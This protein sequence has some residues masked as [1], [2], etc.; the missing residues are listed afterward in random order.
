MNPRAHAEQVT[1]Q[2][3][4]SI[5]DLWSSLGFAAALSDVTGPRVYEY[6]VLPVS[7]VAITLYDVRRHVLIEDGRV[8]RDAAVRAG[9]FRIGI[10]GREVVV[11]AV[12]NVTSGKLVLLYLGEPLLA[13]AGIAFGRDIP[14]EL[15]DRAW[16]VDDPFLT[17][18]AYRLVEASETSRPGY[19]LF[20]EQLALSLAFHVSQRYAAASRTALRASAEAG[21]SSRDLTRLVE[22]VRADPGAPIS[23]HDLARIVGLSPSHLIR[24]FKRSTG[25][26]PH[27]FVLRERIAMARELIVGSDAALTEVALACGFSSQSHLGAAFRAVAGT[28]PARYRR[29]SRD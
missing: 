17:Q 28:T 26:T 7:T 12:P 2:R 5:I 23:I 8:R 11:D 22:F 14:I 6:G 1:G 16:D 4:S 13:E 18:A 9:R 10:P 19:T 3:Q 20:S 21:L 27:R 15:A 24:A 29:L 25:M